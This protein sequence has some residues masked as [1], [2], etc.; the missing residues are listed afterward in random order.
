MTRF[1]QVV[2]ETALCLILATMTAITFI[3]VILRYGFNTGWLWHLE[4]T[5]FLFLW[6]IVIGISYCLRTGVHIGVDLLVNVFPRSGQKA[7]GLLCV[8]LGLIYGGLMLFGAYNGYAFFSSFYQEAGIGM[9]YLDVL[10]LWNIPA[11]ELPIKE[12]ML[13][14][15]LPVGFALLTLTCLEIGYQIITGS[16]LGFIKRE[17]RPDFLRE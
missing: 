1:L 6:M 13:F 8:G 10:L 7:C 3:Q 16:R 14:S 12:W 4:A 2:E 17:T 5:S 9:G 15:I 11:E